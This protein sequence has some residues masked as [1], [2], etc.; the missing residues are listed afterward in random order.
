MIIHPIRPIKYQSDILQ[1]HVKN[2]NKS[3]TRQGNLT[4]HV[5]T[6]HQT[7]VQ[8]SRSIQKQAESLQ[9]PPVQVSK[10]YQPISPEQEHPFRNSQKTTVHTPLPSKITFNHKLTLNHSRMR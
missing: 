4:R 3:F 8:E 5:T 9:S 6:F 10:P 1:W 2:V 7:P